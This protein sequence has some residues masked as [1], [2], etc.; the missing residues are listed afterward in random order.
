MKKIC[1][2][3]YTQEIM[4]IQKEPEMGQKLSRGLMFLFMKKKLKPGVESPQGST[5]FKKKKVMSYKI[6]DWIRF[7]GSKTAHVQ[8]I[9][10]EYQ[11][12]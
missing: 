9:L 3:L 5:N 12:I 11:G 1:T 8:P 2:C 10:V 7:N 4:F 6:D